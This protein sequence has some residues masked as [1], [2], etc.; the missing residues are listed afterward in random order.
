MTSAIVPMIWVGAGAWWPVFPI[1]WFLLLAG[2]LATFAVL[3]SRRA[4]PPAPADSAVAQLA[5][6][7]ARGEIDEREFHERLATLR[8][9]GV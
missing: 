1:L 6:R 5:E 4:K 2:A 3:Y 8:D 7:F 9:A